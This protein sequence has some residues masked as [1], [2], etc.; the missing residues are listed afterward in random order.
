MSARV[1]AIW[2]ARRPGHF[3]LASPSVSRP[4]TTTVVSCVMPRPRS[5]ASIASGERRFQ[6]AGSSSQ[7]VSRKR[8]PGMWPSAYSSGTPKLTWNSRK[9]AVRRRLGPSTVEHL[10]RARRCRRACRSSGRRSSGSASSAAQ[11]GAPP[12]RIRAPSMPSAPSLRDERRGVDVAVAVDDD[13]A[14]GDHALRVE[15]AL[16]SRP[17]RRYRA[18]RPGTRRRRACGRPA[19]RRRGASRCRRPAAGRRRSVRCGSSSR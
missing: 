12:S 11:A 19:R 2:P 9:S 5:A 18:R 14:A 16:R 1:A 4:Y 10:A 7:L 17:R 3:S 13:L 8:A 15:E 6:S